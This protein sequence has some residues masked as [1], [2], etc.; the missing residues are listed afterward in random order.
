MNFE[1]TSIFYLEHLDPE[2]RIMWGMQ[3][4]KYLYENKREMGDS[5]IFIDEAHQLIPAKPPTGW[6]RGH[7]PKIKRQF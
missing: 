7:I 4:V 1:G 6:K 2:E 5:Y 3:L